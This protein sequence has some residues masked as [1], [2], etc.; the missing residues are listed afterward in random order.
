MEE[1]EAG[2][3]EE[4]TA[5]EVGKLGLEVDGDE[6]RL[7]LAELGATEGVVAEEGETTGLATGVTTGVASGV[8]FTGVVFTGVVFTATVTTSVR[9]RVVRIPGMVCSRVDR[10]SEYPA[11]QQHGQRCACGG[12]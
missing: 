8:V 1:A 6:E 10:L 3:G 7:G 11:E 5:G 12:T 4:E 2:E 9:T